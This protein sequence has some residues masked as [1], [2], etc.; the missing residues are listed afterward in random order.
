MRHEC[1]DLTSVLF[2]YEKR[3]VVL[4]IPSTSLLEWLSED[5]DAGV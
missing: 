4:K 1:G 3:R 2:Y 5:V